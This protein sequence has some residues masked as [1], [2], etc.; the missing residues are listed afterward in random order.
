MSDAKPVRV[1]IAPSPTGDPHVGTAYVGLIN[2]A[3]AR[4]NGGKFVLRIEDTD[5]ERSTRA[6]EQA[7]FDALRWVGLEWDEGPD[8]GGPYGPYRQSERTEIYQ[9]YVAE[10]VDR[11]F[12]YPCFCTA[13]EL[14]A[15]RIK[16]RDLKRN[17]GYDGHCRDIP[18]EEAKRRMAAGETHVIRLRVPEGMTVVHDRLRGDVEIENAQIDDQILLKSD[19]FP[20]Y[21]LA[22]VVDDHLMEITHVIRAEEWINS[23]PKHLMLYTAFGWEPPTFV[24][25]PLLRN[26]DKSKISKRKNPVSLLYFK[27]IG[28]LPEAML[29][30]LALLG[31]S[32]Q[33]ER[34]I[35]NLDEFINE[36]SFDRISLG[37][38]V[39][40]LEK[41]MWL[42]GM[43][44]R[45]MEDEELLKRVI[46]LL[47]TPDALRPMIPLIKERI[48]TLGEFS[49]ATSY[50]ALPEIEIPLLEIYKAGKGLTTV[51]IGK[52]L[53]ETVEFLDG[54]REF[55]AETLEEDLRAFSEQKEVSIKILFMMLRLAITGRKATPPLFETFVVIGKAA[56]GQRIRAAAEKIAAWK[57]PAI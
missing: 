28:V 3:F 48:R 54:I 53:K 9:K 34:E 40:D 38:P 45:A 46:D 31:H 57:A 25:L 12:A 36:F 8:V 22:N 50:F 29:N 42:N 20:T 43:R 1:R 51:Q 21:H 37:G 19:G 55:K 17:T 30:F 39:F 4:Q 16:Q 26:Q 27:Q 14:D 44:L 2:M 49:D 15:I 10:I 35:F 23:T 7:I 56:V 32:M 24:H 6:S 13:A 5:Q 41:M 52:L 33:D 18:L 47:Y 11:G